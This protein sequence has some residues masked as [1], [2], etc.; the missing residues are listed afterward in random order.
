MRKPEAGEVLAVA[1]PVFVAE[2]VV[3][4]VMFMGA[5]ITVNGHTIWSAILGMN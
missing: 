1:A 4:V 2:A 5:A 3:V